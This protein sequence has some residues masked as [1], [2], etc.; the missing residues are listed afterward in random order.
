MAVL[1]NTAEQ[2]RAEQSGERGERERERE[3]ERARERKREGRG[4]EAKSKKSS[5]S[6]DA[7]AKLTSMRSVV[8]V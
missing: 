8:V 1:Q 2:S 3:R 5:R 7:A 4:R 6:H